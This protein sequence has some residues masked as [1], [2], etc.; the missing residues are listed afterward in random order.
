MAL[1]A[2]QIQE[3]LPHRYPFLLVDRI[4]EVQP[5]GSDTVLK[6]GGRISYVQDSVIIEDLIAT[7]VAR[8]KAARAEAA[9]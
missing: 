6:T 8:A 5:G 1:D 2:R 3:I 4:I 7:I 9:P